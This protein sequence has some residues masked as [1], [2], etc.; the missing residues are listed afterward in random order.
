MQRWIQLIV[1]G[2]WFRGSN[3][4]WWA[5]VIEA[6][7]AAT[8]LL[9]GFVFLSASI[10]LAIIEAKA[11]NV[12]VFGLHFIL[13]VIIATF[14]ILIGFGWIIRLLW[15]VGVSAERRKAI[16]ARASELEILSE[17]RNRRE[18]LPT[19]PHDGL[20]P[21]PGKVLPFQIVASP[22]NVWRLVSAALSSAITVSIS[23]ILFLIFATPWMT[24]SYLGN[25]FNELSETIAPPELVGETGQPWLAGG[26]LLVFL[27]AAGWSIY[28]FFRQLIKLSGVGPT[29][30]ELSNYP[31]KPGTSCKL[32]LSQTGRVRLQSLKVK[33]ICEEQVTY[34]QGTDIRTETAVV[35]ANRMMRQRGI[36]LTIGRPFE[37]ELEF[38]L[39]P[40]AMHSFK[41]NNS[42]VQWK[43]VVTAKAKNWPLLTRTFRILVFPDS[44]DTKKNPATV[45]VA[46]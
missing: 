1:L 28:H 33:L 30:V 18:D 24:E 25:Q 2:N 38:E 46:N 16:T 19:V 39:P 45:A 14:L 23:S 26:L 7:I 27:P 20:V 44:L 41:S 11:G 34:N 3:R 9:G 22:R 15:H 32:F 31:L 4:R 17:L 29:S 36:S 21:L 10:T 43:I 13:R 5:G 40:T 12:S 8:L 35:F 37:T 6:L 42:R